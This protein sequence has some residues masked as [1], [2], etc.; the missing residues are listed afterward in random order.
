MAKISEVPP[1]KPTFMKGWHSVRHHLG[2]TAFGV[3]GVTVGRGE[4]I[5]KPHHET[6]SNQQELFVVMNGAAEFN[7]D[8]KKIK[9]P[10]GSAIA[11]EPKV[12]RSATALSSPTTVLIVGAEPDAAYQPPAWDRLT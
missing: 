7:L 1:L 12:V 10:T 4:V 8:G 6:G 5:T 11:I 9:V 2:I 3:N